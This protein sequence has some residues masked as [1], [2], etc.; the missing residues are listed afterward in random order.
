[1][2]KR[3]I[4]K[5]FSQILFVVEVQCAQ[6]LSPKQANIFWARLCHEEEGGGGGVP[7]YIV[8]PQGAPGEDATV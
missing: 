3:L 1:M 7:Q 5:G 2:V 6:Y 4:D 8:L